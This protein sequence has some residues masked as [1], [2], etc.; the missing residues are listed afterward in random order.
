MQII[1][2]EEDKTEK[3]FAILLHKIGMLPGP[4]KYSCNSTNFAIQTEL[5]NKTSG[6]CF[7]CCNYKCRKKCQ[8][9]INSIF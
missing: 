8:I 7:R 2:N 3:E 9:K 5:S 1:Q 6:C 4:T